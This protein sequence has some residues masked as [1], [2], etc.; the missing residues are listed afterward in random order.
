MITEIEANRMALPLKATFKRG[1][2]FQIS[3]SIHVSLSI[4]SSFQYI[5]YIF[6]DFKPNKRIKN[7]NV[8]RFELAPFGNRLNYRPLNVNENPPKAILHFN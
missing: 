3:I 1:K 6:K 8:A 4:L 2:F 7:V 5:F